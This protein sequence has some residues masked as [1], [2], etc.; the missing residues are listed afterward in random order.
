M[1]I[2]F[3]FNGEENYELII[4]RVFKKTP[5][6]LNVEL[7]RQIKLMDAALMDIASLPTVEGRIAREH[8][9]RIRKEFGLCEPS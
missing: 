4:Q 2:Q 3:N 9:K 1:S 6:E 8:I 5:A 7:K